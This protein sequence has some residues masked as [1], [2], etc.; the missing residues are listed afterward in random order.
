MAEQNDNILIGEILVQKGIITVEQLEGGLLEQKK[1]GDSICTA[2][3]KLGFASEESIF[4]ALSGQLG[5][6]YV[7]LK[8]KVLDPAVI[9][10]ISAKFAAHYK[11]IPVDCEDE[12]LVVAM[13]DPL[14]VRTLDDLRLVLGMEVKGVLASE[15]E[16]TA[17]IRTYYGVGAET[18]EKIIAQKP[19]MDETS[20][21]GQERVENLEDVAGDASIIQ[22]VNQIL[23]EAVRDR[24]TD[25]HLEPFH[26]ELRCR[27]RID[28][29]LYD[30]PIPETIRHFHSKIV[31][32]IKIMAHLNIVERRLPQDGRI[33]IKIGQQELDLRL[34]TMPTTFGEGVHIRILSN[35]LFLELDKLGLS[36][37]DLGI[38]VE[39]IQ[40]PH[41]VIFVTGPT[42][43]GKSTTLYAA[44]AR[45]NSSAVKIITIEDPVEYQIRGI[46]QVQINPAI[47]FTFGTAL[48]HM[49]RHDPDIMM[50]GEVRDFETAEIT[51]RSAL[52]GHLVFSTLH[53]NDA[54]GGVTRLIEMGIEPF[55]VSSALECLIAQRLVRLICPDCKE[56]VS[57]KRRQEI[58]SGIKDASDDMK[59][60]PLYEGRGCPSCRFTGYRGRTAIYEVLKITEPLR[61][62]ILKRASSQQIRQQAIAHG[63]RTLRCD[64]L[65]KVSQGV[66]TY[67]EVVRVTQLE[68]AA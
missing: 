34:S 44:L 24:A 61:E 67:T 38:I 56:P 52:T 58:L 14:D 12:T 18:L 66:T 28:G 53:T 62:L 50:V 40:K 64:G 48:R 17:A 46:N 37:A 11:I 32:R 33:K 51:I 6:P 45:L 29:I 19:V 35:Q 3:V 1:N 9:K 63:L 2:L 54:A 10:R 16:I 59:T 57:D 15:L 41:G 25:I 22:F 43:S 49:L 26:H 47:G 5:I 30:I 31:S 4:S 60:G 21:Q 39:M 36:P 65:R 23:S 8:E 20:A 13:A 42:G 55:L 7:N 27:F 68:D